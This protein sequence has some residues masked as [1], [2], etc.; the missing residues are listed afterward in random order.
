[1]FFPLPAKTGRSRD[2]DRK[3]INEIIYVLVIWMYRWDDDDDDDDML[4][5]YGAMILQ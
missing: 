3:I 4:K 5:R 2:E 1:M